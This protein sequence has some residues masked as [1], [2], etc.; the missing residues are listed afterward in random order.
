MLQTISV[1]TELPI[2]YHLRT[3]TAPQLLLIALHGYSDHSLSFLRRLFAKPKS[4]RADA[5]TIEWPPSLDAVTV[6]APNG[7][8]P[9]PVKTDEGFKEAYS[10]YFYQLEEQRMIISPAT[11]VA[12]CL[13]ILRQHEL[14]HLPVMIAGFSQGG[15][16]APVLGTELEA[17]GARVCEIVGLGT[18][19]REDYYPR[20][21]AKNW[22]VSALH[23]EADEVFPVANARR[24]HARI[25][26]LGFA[27]DFVTVPAAAHKVTR[28]MGL[29]LE[30]R[31]EFQLAAHSKT[32]RS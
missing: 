9:V 27:G 4:A 28:E 20:T 11:A 30:A 16:L 14:L 32:G 19:F 17:E 24:E 2:S 26:E 5:A 10:W 29:A 1:Q 25:G 22:R 7:P 12:G 6:L 15:Y 21:S 23:G 8:F 18:G 31:I 3:A 13:K